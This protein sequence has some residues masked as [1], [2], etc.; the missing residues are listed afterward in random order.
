MNASLTEDSAPCDEPLGPFADMTDHDAG[1]GHVRRT[2][3]RYRVMATLEMDR[4]GGY[5][6]DP[7]EYRPIPVEEDGETG[8]AFAKV[9]S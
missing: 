4:G 3:L 1:E 5:R 9:R 7:S 6:W 8:F 2:W